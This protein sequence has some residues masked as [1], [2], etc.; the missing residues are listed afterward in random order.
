VRSPVVLALVKLVSLSRSPSPARGLV[1][2]VRGLKFSVPESVPPN[3]AMRGEMGLL[4]PPK[5]MSRGLTP[6][7]LL[8]AELCAIK[9]GLNLLADM[10]PV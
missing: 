10:L 7:M 8:P 1:L 5:E 9:S 6:R 2:I 3:A 4:M